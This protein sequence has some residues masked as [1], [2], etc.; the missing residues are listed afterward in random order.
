[1]AGNVPTKTQ[2]PHF[3][4]SCQVC[5]LRCPILKE[6]YLLN[7]QSPS[8]LLP[9]LSCSHLTLKEIYLHGSSSGTADCCYSLLRNR[10]TLRTL[11]SGH[12]N[13]LPPDQCSSS[14]SS[15]SYG[16]YTRTPFLKHLRS[17][18]YATATAANCTAAS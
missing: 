10:K 11:E 15:T 3:H 1:M 13:L 6:F 9:S 7:S 12:F 14:S 8:C 18:H 17:N 4:I 2:Q 5:Q 16:K